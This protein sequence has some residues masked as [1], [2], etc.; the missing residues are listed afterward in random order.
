[1]GTGGISDGVQVTGGKMLTTQI[2]LVKMLR[3][4]G[5]TPPFPH[6]SSLCDKGQLLELS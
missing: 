3:M 5:N 4:S 2:N 6:M 1:M